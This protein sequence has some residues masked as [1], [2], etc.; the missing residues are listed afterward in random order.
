[1]NK[2]KVIFDYVILALGSIITALGVHFFKIPN[3]FSTGGFSG[4][5][6][7]LGE[8]IQG[9]NT[10]TVISLLNIGSLAFGFIFLGKMLGLKTIY[11]TLIYAG[12]IQLLGAVAPMDIPFTDDRMLELL[13]SFFLGSA[14][15]AIVFKKGG[16]TGGTDI[17][18]LIIRKYFKSDI[19][20]AL[21]CADMLIVLASFAVFDIKT[22]FYSLLGLLL[23]SFGVQIVIDAMNKKK[24]LIIVTTNADEIAKFIT[25][26]VHRGATEWKGHGVFTEDSRS[27]ILTALSPY[28]AAKVSNYAKK[29]DPNAFII[30]NNT[31][32]IYGKGFM[33]MSEI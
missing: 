25:E 8:L 17:I 11:C 24:S 12:V 3:N 19:S 13:F 22:G 29:V 9:L 14:G 5:G 7:L 10:S 33:N 18:A 26:V 16:S 32:E 2:K 27:V 15:S 1:M 6:M 30:V 21:L 4:L 28:Q 23:K 31:H 20:A